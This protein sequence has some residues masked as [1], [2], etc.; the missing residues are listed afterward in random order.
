MTALRMTLSS[1]SSSLD[2]DPSQSAPTDGEKS[3]DTTPELP[4][5]PLLASPQS[6]PP[7]ESKSQSEGPPIANLNL[8]LA[9]AITHDDAHSIYSTED[10]GDD[11]I[12]GSR[13]RG[14]QRTDQ[15]LSGFWPGRFD[16][17]SSSFIRIHC[18][19]LSF[20]RARVEEE[21]AA[22]LIELSKMVLEQHEIPG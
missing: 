8:L 3:G 9:H 16:C 7:S 17:F 2:E 5:K 11:D 19:I 14:L 18:L 12:L 6:P 1:L 22:K 10:I 20:I 15:T 21:Y 13:I 4:V